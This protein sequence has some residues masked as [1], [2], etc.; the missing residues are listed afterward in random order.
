MQEDPR[1]QEEALTG[2]DQVTLANFGEH[3]LSPS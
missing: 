2:V 1:S 3:S